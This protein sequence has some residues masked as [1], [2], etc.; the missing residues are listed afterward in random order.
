MIKWKKEGN[1]LQFPFE[2]ITSNH[3]HYGEM[4]ANS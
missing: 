3:I 4:G 1:T 2:Q